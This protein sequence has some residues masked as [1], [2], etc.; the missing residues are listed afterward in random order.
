MI[1]TKKGLSDIVT[2]VLIILLVLVAV[3]IIWLFLRPTVNSVGNV[4]GSTDCLTIDV[5]PVSCS[6][7]GN[8]VVKRNT[9]QGSLQ[10]LKIILKG[11]A[12]VQ[13]LPKTANATALSELG[14][15]TFANTGSNGLAVPAA[16][17]DTLTVAAVVQSADGL[18]TCNP[19]TKVIT[20]AA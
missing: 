18:K 16:A 6:A 8:I 14:T 7:A 4:Q 19:S 1:M 12:T 20:C 13:D 3:G 2:N 10:G 17:G 9:G 15:L 11:G 5:Q